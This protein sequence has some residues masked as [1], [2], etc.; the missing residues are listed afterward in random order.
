MTNEELTIMLLDKLGW[1]YDKVLNPGHYKNTKDL[2]A[3]DLIFAIFSTDSTPKAAE[4]LGIAYKTI[5]SE[6]HTSELQSH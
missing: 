4:F 6:E 5:R 3:G 2:Y 1:D